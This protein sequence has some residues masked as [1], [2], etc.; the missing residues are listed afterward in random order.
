MS[1]LTR[2]PA[3]RPSLATATKAVENTPVV[4]DG[5]I[6]SA[7]GLIGKKVY[8]LVQNSDTWKL[9]TREMGRLTDVLDNV[10]VAC[11]EYITAV[12]F[13]LADGTTYDYRF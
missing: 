6:R 8:M 13:E 10:E 5:T 4:W 7:Q 11:C 9:E 1:S 12:F 3:G 2:R